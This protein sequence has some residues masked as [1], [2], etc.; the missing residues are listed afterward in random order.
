MI[1]VRAG[2]RRRID[3]VLD[4]DYVT[5]LAELDLAALR[6]RRE[7]ATQEETDLSYLRRLLH[8]R[9]DIVR[10]EQD[11]RAGDGEGAVLDRLATILADNALAPSST[12]ARHQPL[13][14][15]RAGVYQREAEALAGNPDLSDV[16]S[17]DDA[18]L[19]AA[20]RNYRGQEECV[21]ARRREVQTVVDTLGAEIADRYARG[22]ASVDEL[23]GR[24]QSARH[25]HEQHEQGDEQADD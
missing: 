17:L 8:A 16:T 22:A 7:E 20:L 15:S 21:S 24:Q 6:D 4:D 13:E 18:D 9:I 14:P 11:R 2:G 5:G 25:E 3:R 12:Q 23:I 1:E 10:A 19:E